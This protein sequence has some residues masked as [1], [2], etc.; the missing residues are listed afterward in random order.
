MLVI[1]IRW[2]AYPML[3]KTAD[4]TLV[5][6]QIKL[7]QLSIGTRGIAKEFLA[8]HTRD[9]LGQYGF[10]TQMFEDL[11]VFMSVKTKY[12]EMVVHKGDFLVYVGK[13][14]WSLS[15]KCNK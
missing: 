15:K 9:F 1:G 11:M 7:T 12:G 4:T 5:K 8:A 14:I 13:G 6:Q 2:F 10:K 3:F